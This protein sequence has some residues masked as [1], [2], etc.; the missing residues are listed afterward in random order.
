M[1]WDEFMAGADGV[2]PAALA[3]RAASLDF[4]DVVNVQYT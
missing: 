4:D 2:E 1:G 3:E